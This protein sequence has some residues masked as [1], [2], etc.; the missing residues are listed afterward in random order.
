MPQITE[1]TFKKI[2]WENY[3]SIE[4]EFIRITKF[5]ALDTINYAT[6]STAFLK[7]LLELGSEIDTLAKVLCSVAWN[8]TNVQKINEYGDCILKNAP[9]FERVFVVSE[10]IKEIPWQDWGSKSPDWWIAY[11][12][13]KHNR[14]ET[15][16]IGG[17]SQEY[18]KFANLENVVKALMALYQLEIYTLNYLVKQQGTEEG[19]SLLKSSLF[20]LDGERWQTQYFHKSGSLFHKGDILFIDDTITSLK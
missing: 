16:S 7:L 4:E 9:E 6:Y 12:K 19:Y 11:N 8:K 17:V 10:T 15:G 3:L 5:V 13:I 18:F 20:T 2:Y 1:D 14:Y